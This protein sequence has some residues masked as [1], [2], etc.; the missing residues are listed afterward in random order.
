MRIS[1]HRMSMLA[2]AVAAMTIGASRVSAAQDLGLELGSA[3]PSAKLQ[4]LDGKDTDLSAYIG[5]GPVLMEF[6]AVWCPNCKELEPTLLS[7]SKKYGNR[8]KFIGIAVSVNQTPDRVKAFVEKHGLPG[9][10]LF[11]T[12]GNATGAYDVPATSYVV[13]LDKNGKIVYTG[14]GG[15]QDL[16][17]AIKKVL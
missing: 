10:Q 5:K 4:T 17:S 1:L 6:W 9:D 2:A 12:K 8:V 16:E 14:L 3:A 15:K 11:D 7:V 13:V